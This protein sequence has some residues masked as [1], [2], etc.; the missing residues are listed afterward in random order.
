[1]LLDY[2]RCGPEGEPPVVFCD[3]D[4]EVEGRPLEWTLAPSFAALEQRLQ[5]VSSRTQVA[6]QGDHGCGVMLDALRAAGAEDPPRE[7]YEGGYT[8]ALVGPNSV[9]PG[10]ARLRVVPNLRPDGTRNFPELPGHGWV[11]ETTVAPEALFAHLQRLEAV[12]PGPAV[13]LHK[14][15]QVVSSSRGF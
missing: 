6:V 13:L 7:D 14:A 1:M 10:P 11:V 3:T 15:E 8:L 2:R 4:H 5:Y 12:L 9:E